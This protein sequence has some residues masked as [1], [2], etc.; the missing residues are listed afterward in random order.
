M[1]LGSLFLLGYMGYGLFRGA[2]AIGNKWFNSIGDKK[3]A[4]EKNEA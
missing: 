4:E 1:T 3:E 2:K